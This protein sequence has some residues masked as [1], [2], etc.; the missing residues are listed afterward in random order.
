MP[1]VCNCSRR[2]MQGF[3]GAMGLNEVFRERYRAISYVKNETEKGFA[4]SDKIIRTANYYAW[5]KGDDGEGSRELVLSNGSIGFLNHNQ[6][7]WKAHFTECTYPLNWSKMDPEDFEAAYAISVHKA[8]GS[9]F[10]EVFVVIPE[11]RGLL[12]RELVYTAMT[13]SKGAFTLFVQRTPRENPLEIARSR[14]E[15]LAATVH[16]SRRG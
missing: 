12:S 14:S 16:C 9:E 13:R 10:D 15:L 4:H 7:G 3:S 1:I 6:A 8:Q 11:R 2:T 5:V